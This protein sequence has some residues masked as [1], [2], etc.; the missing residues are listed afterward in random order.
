MIYL[1][2]INIWYMAE[3][4]KNWWNFLGS[5]AQNSQKLAHQRSGSHFT[6]CSSKCKGQNYSDGW[7][8]FRWNKITCSILV[9]G[10]K[11]KFLETPIGDVNYHFNE[12]DAK[13]FCILKSAVRPLF[14]DRYRNNPCVKCSKL[15]AKIWYAHGKDLI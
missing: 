7:N 3:E 1:F 6:I 11:D 12:L 13:I 9:T 5:S 14:M 15:L 8:T 2:T 10:K 4:K